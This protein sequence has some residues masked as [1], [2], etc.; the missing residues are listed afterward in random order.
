[1]EQQTFD[2]AEWDGT[3][4]RVR[5]DARVASELMAL[6]AAAIAAVAEKGMD[7]PDE[8]KSNLQQDHA[9]AP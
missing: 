7:P 2:F 5:L 1:M 8:H 4:Y 6:M 9:D 3:V